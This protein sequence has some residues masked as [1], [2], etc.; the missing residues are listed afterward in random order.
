MQVSV[1]VRYIEGQ[2]KGLGPL[3]GVSVKVRYIE[4]Q[5]KGLGPLGAGQYEGQIYRGSV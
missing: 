3:G 4:G 2:C 1:R 5:C